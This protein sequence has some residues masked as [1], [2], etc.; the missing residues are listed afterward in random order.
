[1][2]ADEEKPEGTPVGDETPAEA[3]SE[4]EVKALIDSIVTEA[5]E[6]AVKPLLEDFVKLSKLHAELEE[7]HTKLENDIMGVEWKP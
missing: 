7:K 1:M 3:V 6:K 2:K 4:E 5:V